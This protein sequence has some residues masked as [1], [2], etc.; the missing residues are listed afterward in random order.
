MI[1]YKRCLPTIMKIK[2][3]AEFI[4]WFLYI[5]LSIVAV[6]FIIASD[7][8]QKYLKKQTDTYQNEIVARD[9][10]V[11]EFRFCDVPN[12]TLGLVNQYEVE[13]WVNDL[14]LGTER[15][16]V[17][18]FTKYILHNGECFVLIPPAGLNLTY[19]FKHDIVLRF[20]TSIPF[21]DLPQITGS[22]TSRNN[23]WLYG[24]HHD[25][26]VMLNTINAGEWAY[27]RINEERMKYLPDNCRSQPILDF[28]V[29]EFGSAKI[30]C[31]EKCFPKSL[32][33][34]DYFEEKM[35]MYPICDDQDSNQCV[36]K[37][38]K[39]LLKNSKSYCNKISYAGEVITFKIESGCSKVLKG[40]YDAT[41]I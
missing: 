13:Y 27:F 15:K 5:I 26:S 10:S 14:A 16:R 38:V 23:P 12:S 36:E 18:Y 29:T 19:N 20:N 28:L 34:G 4:D 2:N 33:L 22:I 25:G 37:W 9:F 39:K 6:Y 41:I 30:N 40:N 7:V 32:H 3:T 1:Q 11:P 24:I 8:I 21:E 17:D 35:K 31:S